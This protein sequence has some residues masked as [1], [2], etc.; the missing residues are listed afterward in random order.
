MVKDFHKPAGIPAACAAVAAGIAFG[1]A[2]PA[3]AQQQ[4]PSAQSTSVAPR[5]A[6]PGAGAT[7]YTDMASDQSFV[8]EERGRSA[9]LRLEGTGEVIPLQAVPA[10]R[11][12][13]FLRTPSGESLLRKTEA[14]NMVSYIGNKNGAPA[15]IAGRAAPLNAPPMPASLNE[16]RTEAAANLSKMAGH[17]VTIFGTAEFA[18]HEQWAADALNNVEIGVER[19]NGLAGRVAA[20]LS[21][22]RLV[23]ADA[24]SVSFEDGELVLGV[25]PEQGYL[26]RVSSDDISN[27]LTASRSAG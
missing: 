21:A 9:L 2:G 23:R 20:K 11:G 6:A 4:P 8:L 1:L 3:L 10:Q 22:V 25:N 12:D 18:D 5:P 7:R 16:L 26:G 19:A 13:T 27:A 15:D 17:D 14:G 24:P